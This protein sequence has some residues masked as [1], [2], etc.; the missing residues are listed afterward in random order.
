MSQVDL[1][2]L[3]MPGESPDMEHTP[4]Q[5][6]RRP[7][8]L[9]RL[10]D[11]QGRAL[12]RY[13]VE[14]KLGLRRD[15]GAAKLKRL[16]A[17]HLRIIGARIAGDSLQKIAME[18]GVTIAT[19]SRVLNDPLSQNL[20]KKVYGD[21]QDQIQALGAKAIAACA[22]A[23]HDDQTMGTR[24]RGVAAYT[25]IREVMLPKDKGTESA[26]DVIARML[27]NGSFVNNGTINIAGNQQINSG[28]ES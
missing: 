17:R 6:G 14:K 4:G 3:F 9:P 28:E 1:M 25:K 10:T 26:E 7:A 18:Q 22:E 20:L 24:L 2:S 21:Q 12:P 15:N 5:R 16:T 23:L 13:L 11:N 8:N 27:A 19:A